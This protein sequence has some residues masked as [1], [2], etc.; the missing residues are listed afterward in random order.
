MITKEQALKIM[1]KSK[2][3]I[4]SSVVITVSLVFTGCNQA[5][6]VSYNLSQQADSFNIFRQL[7]VT[8]LVT[9]D[10]LF[11]MR[12]K[13]S[14]QPKDNR[15]EIIV[16]NDMNQYIILKCGFRMKLKA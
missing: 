11:Q 1:K 4:I 15:L 14:I 7:T 3:A 10:N 6:K 16:E 12:G 8:S 5:E 9:G 2:I 13:M